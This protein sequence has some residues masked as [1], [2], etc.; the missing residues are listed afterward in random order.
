MGLE[1]DVAE[2]VADAQDAL[3]DL[4]VDVTVTPTALDGEG[5]ET[6][7]ASFTAPAFVE[8][9]RMLRR[10]PDGRMVETDSRVLFLSSIEVGMADRVAD[11]TGD[12]GPVLYVGGF[13]RRSG[14]TFYT[15]V[16]M[17]GLRGSGI[18]ST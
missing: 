5:T 18:G 1:D 3:V 6:P 8:R 2:A 12:L 7:K 14:G 17:G 4:A 11:A 10:M 9:R 16:W 15:E 13:R